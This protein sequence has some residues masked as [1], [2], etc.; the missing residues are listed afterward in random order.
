MR[1]VVAEF[2]LESPFRDCD[3]PLTLTNYTLDYLEEHWVDY[4]DFVIC[5]WRNS[6]CPSGLLPDAPF[7]G[8]RR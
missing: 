3:S 1:R 2:N 8:G 6:H 7:S 5:A 4:V